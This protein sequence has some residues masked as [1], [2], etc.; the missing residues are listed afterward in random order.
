MRENFMSVLMRGGWR[1]IRWTSR[2]LYHSY[3][4]LAPKA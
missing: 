4:R 2:L 3:S 1:G